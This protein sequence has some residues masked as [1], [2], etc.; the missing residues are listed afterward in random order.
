M[1]KYAKLLCTGLQEGAGHI[2]NELLF[3]EAR[4]LL[5]IA[6]LLLN[7]SAQLEHRTISVLDQERNI[8]RSIHLED[9]VNVSLLGHL[10]FDH[11][12]FDIVSLGSIVR[13]IF[14]HCTLDWSVLINSLRRDV[15]FKIICCITQRVI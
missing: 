7:C 4:H 9:V 12:D 3:R 10:V 14:N 13:F 15:C 2:I 8:A 6:D 11:A 5:S 1:Q